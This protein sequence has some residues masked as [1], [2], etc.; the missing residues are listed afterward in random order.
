M[1]EV[2]G[3]FNTLWGYIV[4]AFDVMHPSLR[5]LFALAFIGHAAVL[6]IVWLIRRFFIQHH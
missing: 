4:Q 5:V 3:V 2:F 6:P 1:S